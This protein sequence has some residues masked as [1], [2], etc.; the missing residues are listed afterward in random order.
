M[1]RV[2]DLP[3]ETSSEVPKLTMVGRGDLLVENHTGVLQYSKNKIRLYTR[4]GILCIEGC[5]LELLEFGVSRAYIRGEISSCSY[6]QES[7]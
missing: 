5:K 6:P 7:E 1:L 4:E 2:L 3:E